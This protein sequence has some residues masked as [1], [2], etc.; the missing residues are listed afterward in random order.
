MSINETYT[1]EK[2]VLIHGIGEVVIPRNI[3]VDNIKMIAE[4]LKDESGVMKELFVVKESR[5]CACLEPCLC[6]PNKWN[7]KSILNKLVP[8]EPFND[9][10]NCICSNCDA[11]GKVVDGVVVLPCINCARDSD[12]V[13]N[14]VRCLGTQGDKELTPNELADIYFQSQKSISHE[15]RI[16]LLP[17]ESKEYY[18]HLLTSCKGGTAP[19]W[20]TM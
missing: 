4:A 10:D 17:E 1:S 15:D 5:Y 8:N 11:Y 13:W 18:N 2:T 20:N 9:K 7:S 6:H 12:Y 16:N 14:G 19:A 3:T